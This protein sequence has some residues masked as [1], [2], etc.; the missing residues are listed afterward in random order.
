[1]FA[2]GKVVSRFPGIDDVYMEAVSKDAVL[3]AVFSQNP[4]LSILCS[5]LHR[6]NEMHSGERYPSI[7]KRK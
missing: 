5:V 7:V 6:Q 4:V 1:M 3:A 2:L